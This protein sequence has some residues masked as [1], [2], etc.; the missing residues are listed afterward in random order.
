MVLPG[1]SLHGNCDHKARTPYCY[2]QNDPVAEAIYVDGQRFSSAA[3]DALG[4]DAFSTDVND[5]HRKYIWDFFLPLQSCPHQE[6]L[7][8]LAT[9]GDNGKW[10]CGVSYPQ[11]LSIAPCSLGPML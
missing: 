1:P 9:L 11:R 10:I 4:P 2:A 3:L 7:G 6:K 5:N 8:V